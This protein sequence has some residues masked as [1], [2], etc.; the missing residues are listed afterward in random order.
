MTPIVL[1]GFQKDGKIR[2]NLYQ[3]DIIRKILDS[4]W[5]SRGCVVWLT[6][7]PGSGKTTTANELQKELRSK[8]IR[9]QILDGD[10]VRKQL[11]PELGFSKADRESHGRRVAY[12][13]KILEQHKIVTI[14]CL[15]SPYRSIRDYARSLVNNFVEV[16]VECSVDT[17][18]KRDPKGLYSKAAG[19]Q[20]QNLTGVQDPYEDPVRAEIVLDTEH[21]DNVQCVQQI[22]GYLIEH[23]LIEYDSSPMVA[24]NAIFGK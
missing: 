12:I 13:S 18:R 17:C 22:L 7:L 4:K 24:S 6:G 2:N 20:V 14:V 23:D 21:E 19:G 5:S 10:E 11:S 9:V 15:I 8:G 3:D 16:W 1:I